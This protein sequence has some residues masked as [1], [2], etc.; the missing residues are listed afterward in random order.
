LKFWTGSFAFSKGFL[1]FFFSLGLSFFLSFFFS[2]TSG[3]ESS[4]AV[5]SLD[6]YFHQYQHVNVFCVM[7]RTGSA[8]GVSICSVSGFDESAAFLAALSSRTNAYLKLNV[9][10]MKKSLSAR[11]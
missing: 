3:A 11:I 9:S 8:L 5:N 2:V 1:S 4:G 6:A 10:I 7:Y